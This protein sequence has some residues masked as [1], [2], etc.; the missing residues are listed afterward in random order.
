MDAIDVH[1]LPP[2]MLLQRKIGKKYNDPDL[3]EAKDFEDFY[4]DLPEWEH[5]WT[6]TRIRFLALHQIGP[7]IIDNNFNPKPY[8]SD[9]LL[10]LRNAFRSVEFISELT[11]EG[12]IYEMAPEDIAALGAV[13]GD[14]A[15][16]LAESL[17]ETFQRLRENAPYVYVDEGIF[18][19]T[20]NSQEVIADLNS[21]VTETL[22]EYG[23]RFD[24]PG[25]LPDPPIGAVLLRGG[26]FDPYDMIVNAE[27]NPLLALYG[28]TLTFRHELNHLW[29]FLSNGGSPFYQRRAL[30]LTRRRVFPGWFHEGLAG[31]ASGEKEM[32]INTIVAMKDPQILADICAD[33]FVETN[34][35]ALFYLIGTLVVDTFVEDYGEE[36]I[37]DLITKAKEKGDFAAALTELFAANGNYFVYL[38]EL[39]QR[40]TTRISKLA[41]LEETEDYAAILEAILPGSRAD[42]ESRDPEKNSYRAVAMEL[43]QQARNRDMTDTPVD[44]EVL[45]YQKMLCE[46]FLQKHPGSALSLSVHYLAGL[47]HYILSDGA[48]AKQH[49]DA[50][51]EK[52]T[53]FSR[54]EEAVFY[55]TLTEARWGEG[56]VEVIDE[57]LPYFH[58]LSLQQ[59]KKVKKDLLR[60]R[61]PEE[62]LSVDNEADEIPANAEEENPPQTNLKVPDNEGGCACSTRQQSF[63]NTLSILSRR[64]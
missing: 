12:G 32:R 30:E 23:D 36:V 8:N 15:F 35:W 10:L 18:E 49:F 7:R 41:T 45:S 46:T 13:F 43:E 22:A 29:L 52:V 58:G 20:P 11:P 17:R 51:L 61:S 48:K 57:I 54:S 26:L 2:E 40:V 33:E 24:Y 42:Y 25:P 59:A 1:L 9:F 16:D 31:Y 62:A 28:D 47:L 14:E 3:L 34:N 63:L 55:A 56:G 6:E 60:V 27:V 21:A 37:G 53:Q 39:Q 19:G 50:I 4:E 5:Y 38:E 44:E 64:R